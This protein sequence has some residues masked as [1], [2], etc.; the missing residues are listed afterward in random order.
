LADPPRCV[1]GEL[2]TFF[3]IEALDGPHET[4]VPFLDQVEDAET[5]TLVTTGNTDDQPQVALDEL[6]T[7]IISGVN[8]TQEKC[9][10]PT[11]RGRFVVEAFLGE[12]TRNHE[13]SEALLVSGCQERIRAD[14]VEILTKQLV[15]CISRSWRHKKEGSSVG[16]FRGGYLQ[17][18]R[19]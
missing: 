8:R 7:S 19:R 4:Q 13:L 14:V 17:P 12:T 1:C 3:V 5:G 10:I 9:S 11:L 6:G 2:E 16:C 18:S 15:L